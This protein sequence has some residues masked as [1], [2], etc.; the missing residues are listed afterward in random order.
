MNDSILINGN[1]TEK[2]DISNY[3]EKNIINDKIIIKDVLF[4][5]GCHTDKVPH[6]FKYRVSHQMEQLNAGFIDIDEYSNFHCL[7][8]RINVE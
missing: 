6:P 3:K 8:T 5:N 7:W 4:I 1:D 2:I